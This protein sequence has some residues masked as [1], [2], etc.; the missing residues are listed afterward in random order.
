MPRDDRRRPP[1]TRRSPR[2]VEAGDVQASVTYPVAGSLPHQPVDLGHCGVQPVNASGRWPHRWRATLTRP[3]QTRRPHP[4]P[5]PGRTPAWPNSGSVILGPVPDNRH[6]R[7][8]GPSPQGSPPYTD[9]VG[10]PSDRPRN[11]PNGRVTQRPRC[12]RSRDRVSH[13]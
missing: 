11:Q 9:A 10:S 6:Y 1:A 4:A 13:R 2:Q 7:Q 3:Q 12:A 8:Q 5:R